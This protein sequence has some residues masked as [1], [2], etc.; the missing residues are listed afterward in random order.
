MKRMICRMAA[1][2]NEIPLLCTGITINLLNVIDCK[3]FKPMHIT[4]NLAKKNLTNG[5]KDL[6]ID[7]SI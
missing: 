5:E 3:N 4:I 2:F 7:V 6:I 1:V